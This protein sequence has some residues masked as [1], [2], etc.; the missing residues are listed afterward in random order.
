MFSHEFIHAID[1]QEDDPYVGVMKKWADEI[2]EARM[3]Q[4]RY[5][6]DAEAATRAAAKLQGG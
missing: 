2:A 6:D 1:D 4:K 3:Y 5:G